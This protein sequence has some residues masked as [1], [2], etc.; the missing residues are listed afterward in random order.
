MKFYFAYLE[1]FYLFGVL[2]RFPDLL[3]I[4]L[5]KKKGDH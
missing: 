1:G 5:M 2:M 4:I 3:G